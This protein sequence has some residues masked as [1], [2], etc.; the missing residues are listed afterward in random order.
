MVTLPI[1]FGPLR[2]GV[3][4]PARVDGVEGPSPEPVALLL[5]RLHLSPETGGRRMSEW[6]GPLIFALVFNGIWALVEGIRAMRRKR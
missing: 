3:G 5:R 4:L 6:V 2:I 1:R